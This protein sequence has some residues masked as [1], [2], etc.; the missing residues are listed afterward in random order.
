MVHGIVAEQLWQKI[1][2]ILQIWIL[3]PR[4]QLLKQFQSIIE[5][6]NFENKRILIWQMM[7]DSWSFGAETPRIQEVYDFVENLEYIFNL[8]EPPII[9][10]SLYGQPRYD[11]IMKKIYDIFIR[12]MNYEELCNSDVPKL[13]TLLIHTS[14]KSVIP[15]M[16]TV[17]SIIGRKLM[18]SDFITQNVKI[19]VLVSNS[20]RLEFQHIIHQNIPN[21]YESFMTLHNKLND[22]CIEYLE[23]KINET[24]L[25]VQIEIDRLCSMIELA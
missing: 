4:I 14:K 18:I 24:N 12:Y 3:I 8:Q 13:M 2:P 21:F 11:N 15:E 6:K 25:I 19:P 9:Y 22:E 16:I 7:Q 10:N 23:N 17:Y 20:E 1:T 5:I